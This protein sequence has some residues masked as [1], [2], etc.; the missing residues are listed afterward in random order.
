MVLQFFKLEDVAMGIWVDKY[1]SLKKK[2]VD[3]VTYD[4]YQHGVCENGFII[5]HYQ[6]PSQMQCLWNNA[7]NGEHG[8]CCNNDI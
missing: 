5:S 4:N 6:N 1:K 7:M 3:Y 8:I 2:V